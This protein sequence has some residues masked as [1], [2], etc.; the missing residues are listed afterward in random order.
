MNNEN[1]LYL[2]YKSLYGF[3]EENKSNNEKSNSSDKLHRNTKKWAFNTKKSELTPSPVFADVGKISK[4]VFFPNSFI[5]SLVT[6][7]D[8]SRSTLFSAIIN[9]V[10]WPI[11]VLPSLIQNLSLLN[12]S[13]FIISNTSI[14]PSAA[15]K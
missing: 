12:D 4:F 5:A 7:L 3:N 10:S 6:A 9:S 11:F 14:T 15:R 2:D 8:S 13:L 1:T